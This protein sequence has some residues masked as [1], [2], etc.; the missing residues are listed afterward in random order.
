MDASLKPRTLPVVTS[1]VMNTISIA[2]LGPDPICQACV[3][4]SS[5]GVTGDVNLAVIILSARLSPPA[6]VRIIA[7]AANP[8]EDRP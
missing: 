6:T 8:Y 5:P 4:S 1:F 7:L 3:S 2:P